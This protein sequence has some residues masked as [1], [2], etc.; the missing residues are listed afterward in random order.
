VSEIA[1]RSSDVNAWAGM[2]R[3]LARS[4][5]IA[6]ACI[7]VLTVLGWAALALMAADSGTVAAP[8]SWL[9]VLC[10]ATPLS[11]SGSW[12]VPMA[13]LAIVFG[14]WAAM[15]LAM[16]LPTA[17]PMILTYAE[18]AETAQRKGEPIVSPVVLTAGYIAVWLGFALL[19]SLLQIAA[20]RAGLSEPTQTLPG[21]LV[22]AALFL[23]AGLYQFSPLKHACLTQCRRPLPF[24]FAHW[25]TSVGGVLGLGL[26]QGAYCLGCCWALMLLMLA[27]GAMN[28][29]W[30]A[31]LGVIMTVEK[32]T[33]SARFSR[34]VGLILLL[35]GLGFLLSAGNAWRALS[36]SG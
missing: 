32:L 31:V 29:I 5:A 36:T 2:A 9:D 13:E 21:A 7:A 22:S 27:A 17:G 35:F 11:A 12:S 8:G 6:S 4:R 28:M 26:R 3:V 1:Q 34:L 25:K 30:A 16:M 19:A 23:T 10:R 15:V 33:S 24:F 20:S 18:I 14:M